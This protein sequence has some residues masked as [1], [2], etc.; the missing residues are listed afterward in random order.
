MAEKVTARADKK[1]DEIIAQF[2]DAKYVNQRMDSIFKPVVARIQKDTTKKDFTLF[3]LFFG[4]DE[5][6]DIKKHVKQAIASITK[7]IK[8][9][10]VLDV[11]VINK[12]VGQPKSKVVAAPITQSKPKGKAAAPIIINTKGVEKK[13][14]TKD[15]FEANKTINVK[16]VGVDKSVLGLLKGLYTVKGEVTKE[17]TVA[18]K[19]SGLLEKLILAALSGF[20]AAKFLAAAWGD[21]G[22]M[23]GAMKLIGNVLTRTAAFLFQSIMSSIKGFVSPILKGLVKKFGAD[24]LIGKVSK[25][26]EAPI[27][28]IAEMG[29]K[30]ISKIG[31]VL[32]DGIAKISPAA[33]KS[34]GKLGGGLTK[35]L[36]PVGKFLFKRLKFIPIIG[37]L[38]SLGFGIKRMIDGDYI[39]GIIEVVGGLLGLIDLAAPGVGTAL[40]LAVDVFLAGRDIKYGGIEN[41]KKGAGNQW[42][43]NFAKALID[44]GPIRWLRTIGESLGMMMSGEFTDG[45]I[46]FV[47]TVGGIPGADFVLGLFGVNKN[48]EGKLIGKEGKN[49]IDMIKNEIVDKIESIYK[50][51][52][53]LLGKVRNFFGLGGKA[54]ENITDSHKSMALRSQIVE[55]KTKEAE[56]LSKAYASEATRQRRLNEFATERAAL[57]IQLNGLSDKIRK[58]RNITASMQVAMPATTE[59]AIPSDTAVNVIPTTTTD[60]VEDVRQAAIKVAQDDHNTEVVDAIKELNETQKAKVNTQIADK[61]EKSS[62]SVINATN[63]TARTDTHV[64]VDTARDSIFVTRDNLRNYLLGQRLMV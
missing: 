2:V 20:T 23:R 26:L 5:I 9:K 61:K 39:G 15:I 28:N 3:S 53:G 14:S 29:G 51:G 62:M 13:S 47:N 54:D 44:T 46:K 52:K 32:I 59:A 43:G 64:N 27:K 12:I 41:I 31:K 42:I 57:E 56:E 38:M 7:N 45:F 11:Q 17:P 6:D 37:T 60:R 50:W 36:G 10:D 8:P 18:N 33:A 19:S 49:V 30:L 1:I 22:P 21:Q 4:K 24:S 63:T 48:P 55:L 40:N 58:S 16:I 25:F 34:I 35:L